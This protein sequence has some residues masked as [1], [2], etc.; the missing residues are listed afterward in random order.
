MAVKEPQ[1]RGAI[2][3]HVLCVYSKPFVFPSSDEIAASWKLGFVKITAPKIR[4]RLHSIAGYLGKYIGKGY[5][6][7]TLELKKSFSASQIK[8]IYKLAPKRLAEVIVKYGKENAETFKMNISQS[9]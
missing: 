5:E 3:Y 4:L 1:K 6:Y 8:Q 2:H 9:V 7:E